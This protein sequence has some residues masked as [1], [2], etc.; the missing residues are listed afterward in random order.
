MMRGGARGRILTTCLGLL[1]VAG[2]VG[3]CS[4]DESGDL[5]PADV[6]TLFADV[7][8]D[9]EP[10]E[11]GEELAE[12][13][14]AVVVAELISL[15]TGP[16]VPGV[17]GEPVPGSNVIFTFEV[18]ERLSGS[19]ASPE[20]A[21]L[22]PGT[23]DTTQALGDSASIEASGTFILYME[24]Y[25]EDPAV[26]MVGAVP[27]DLYIP[28]GP[29]GMYVELDSSTTGVPLEQGSVISEP[30]AAFSPSESPLP[31]VAEH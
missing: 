22:M 27:E 2:S 31:V 15:A 1:L 4:M 7:H 25:V 11:T 30:L 21:L 18:S 14:D 28:V 3:S 12:L 16:A 20:V 9:Y 6:N 5:S 19:A 17:D 13:S 10:V 24:Q 29:Q 23:P 26:P 8:Y